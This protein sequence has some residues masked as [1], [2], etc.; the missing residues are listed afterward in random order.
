MRKRYRR[1]DRQSLSG[2]KVKDPYH[3]NKLLDNNEIKS[4][5]YELYA[6]KY[7]VVYSQ[8]EEARAE[9]VRPAEQAHAVRVHPTE[10]TIS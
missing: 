9:I 1:L 6:I 7:H 2:I 4:K 10:Q 5:I 3:D 8:I